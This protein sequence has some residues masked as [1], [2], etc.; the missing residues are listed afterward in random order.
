MNRS[1]GTTSIRKRK[2]T[3]GKEGQTVWKNTER[4]SEQPGIRLES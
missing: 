3:V 4:L 1:V 2:L